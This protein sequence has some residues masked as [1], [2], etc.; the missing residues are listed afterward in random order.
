MAPGYGQD[1]NKCAAACVEAG[2]TSGTCGDV[3]YGYRDVTV[4]GIAGEYEYSDVY[5]QCACSS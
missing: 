1:D 3:Q 5:L 4:C 2:F